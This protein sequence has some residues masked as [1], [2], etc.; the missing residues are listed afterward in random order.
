M[1]C[2]R[3]Y[4]YS[5]CLQCFPE[6]AE[7]EEVKAVDIPISEPKPSQPL[8]NL[9]GLPSTSITPTDALATSL[10]DLQIKQEIGC[11]HKECVESAQLNH[12]LVDDFNALTTTLR[13]L[14]MAIGTE[15]TETA[16]L[17]QLVD[18]NTK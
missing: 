4:R 13:D 16:R 1:S 8:S 5:N 15:M 7:S 6:I 17:K 12:L 10:L 18:Q 2:Q 9:L 14:E 11:R 3:S